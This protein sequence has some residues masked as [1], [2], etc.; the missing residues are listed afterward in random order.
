MGVH[1]CVTVP[2]KARGKQRPRA[3]RTKAGVRVYTPEETINAEGW[4]RACWLD[5]I[6]RVWLT[7]PLRVEIDVV[8]APPKS[9]SKA[10][11][12][13]A[14]ANDLRPTTKP[15]ADNV[16]KLALDALNGVAWADD[17]Q[18]V[19]LEVRKLFGSE[20]EM[21]LRVIPL[22]EPDEMALFLGA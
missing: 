11:L 13:L 16:A 15:D 22:S 1:A 5:Q 7:G 2:G 4:V 14:L 8:V 6:G 17:V 20:P 10:R 18:V 21:V 19:E 9:L 3:V 12:S